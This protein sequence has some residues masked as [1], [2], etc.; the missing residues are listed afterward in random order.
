MRVEA[1]LERDVVHWATK[2]MGG[3]ALK[4]KL[5]GRRGFPDRTLLLP[6]GIAVFPEL[7]RSENAAKRR[8]Q[9][10]W[11]ERLRQLGFEAAFCWS[12]EQV[13]GLYN[14]HTKHN[15]KSASAT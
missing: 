3:E 5:D 10:W 11:I 1:D 7:K 12:L 6:G 4:L 15:T 8:Q 9:L 14:E 2:W 13:T